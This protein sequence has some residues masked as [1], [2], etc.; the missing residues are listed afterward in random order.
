[1]NKAFAAGLCMQLAVLC[2]PPLQTVFSTVPMD[3][4]QWG[5]VLALAAAPV[6]VCELVKAAA[7]ARDRRREKRGAAES[8]PSV[9]SP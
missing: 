3:A 7:R 8:A 9:P 6:A 2:L 5:A 1:M 4:P